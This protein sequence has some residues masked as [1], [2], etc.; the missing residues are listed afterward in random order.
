[1]NILDK[2]T[3]WAENSYVD[4][5][6]ILAL[7]IVLIETFAQINIK[8][9]EIG[10]YKFIIGLL[11]YTILGFVLHYSYHKFDLG[12]INVIWSCCSIIIALTIGYLLYDEVMSTNK[13]I[14]ALLALSAIIVLSNE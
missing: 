12:K 4:E 2:I 1:M 7:I 3:A 6:L 11:F 5:V 13:I 9:S 10:T 14:S 8:S